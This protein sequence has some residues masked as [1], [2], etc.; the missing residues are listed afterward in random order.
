MVDSS[1]LSHLKTSLKWMHL[2]GGFFTTEPPDNLLKMNASGR[3][4]TN[5]GLRAIPHD[6]TGK[7]KQ[8]CEWTGDQG[9]GKK[10]RERTLC[11]RTRRSN[12]PQAHAVWA[13]MDTQVS[14]LLVLY[15][16]AVGA[17]M[18]ATSGAVMTEIFYTVQMVFPQA[19]IHLK[20][21]WPCYIH[22]MDHYL[23]IK[24]E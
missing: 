8:R 7:W 24:K 19:Q 2:G 3:I 16:T 15:M 23:S 6:S 4:N 22:T 17:R 5:A 21:H 14:V 20:A 9:L 1:P 10:R 11:S 18:T 12:W 13:V